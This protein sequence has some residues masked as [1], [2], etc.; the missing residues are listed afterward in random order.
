MVGFP[1]EN[2]GGGGFME[3]KGRGSRR[4]QTAVGA[5][6]LMKRAIRDIRPTPTAVGGWRQWKGKGKKREDEVGERVR[7][8][9]FN[10]E[11]G[12]P[13]KASKRV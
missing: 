8:S 7:D 12:V 5:G 1:P 2:D 3:E 13:A 6:G 9:R 11:F 10:R 4:Q